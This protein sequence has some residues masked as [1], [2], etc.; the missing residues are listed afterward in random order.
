MSAITPPRYRMSILDADGNYYTGSLNTDS[1]WSISSSTTP[2]YL[3]SLPLNWQNMELT[4]AR[5]STYLGIVRSM[6]G[7]FEFATDGYAILKAFWYESG[8]QA[9]AQLQIE[10][11]MDTESYTGAGDFWRYEP[12]YV[13]N[14]DFSQAMVD[15]KVQRISVNTLDSALYELVK[16]Y[17]N[18]KYNIPFWDY[19][20]TSDSFTTEGTFLWHDGIKLLYNSMWESGATPSSIIQRQLGWTSGSNWDTIIPPTEPHTFLA[21]APV[22]YT[23]N[24]GT[25]TYIGND[26][27]QPWLLQ[28]SQSDEPNQTLWD[29]YS[30]NLYLLKCLAQSGTTLY[31]RVTANITNITYLNPAPGDMSM[32][33]KFRMYE[34]GFF[35]PGGGDTPTGVTDMDI[36]LPHQSGFSTGAVVSIAPGAVQW[37]SAAITLSYDKVYAL[38]ILYC[39]ATDPGG[40]DEA[41]VYLSSFSVAILSD[42]LSN[43]AHTTTTGSY[44]AYGAPMLQASPAIAY[45]PYQVFEKLVPCLNSIAT[46]AYG[47]PDIPPHTPYSGVSRFLTDARLHLAANADAIPALTLWTSGNALRDINGQPYISISLS[48]F[49]KVMRS[50]WGCGM[51]IE[52]DRLRI[53]PLTYFF[54]SSSMIIDLGSNVDKFCVRPLTEMLGNN[55][56]S[57]YNTESA[58]NDFGVDEWNREMDYKT[59]I[60]RVVQDIEAVC[61][62]ITS[63]YA[64]EKAR[65]QQSSQPI[66]SP[67][68]SNE[69]YLIGISEGT[70]SEVGVTPGTLTYPQGEGSYYTMAMLNKQPAMKNYDDGAGTPYV[71]NMYYGD[72][73]YNIELSPARNMARSSALWNSLFENSAGSPG[74]QFIHQYQ[75]LYNNIASELPGITSDLMNG[76]GEFTEVADIPV[77]SSPQLFRPYIL[78]IET[79]QPVNMYS[80]INHNAYGYIQFSWAGSQYQGFIWEVKQ[81]PEGRSTIFQLLCCPGVVLP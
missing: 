12:F 49:C 5:N 16:A 56:K 37:V 3:Q 65:A 67:S 15:M 7:T 78:E 30:K 10:M 13:S 1:S 68:S 47:F 69:N 57:G 80:I 20:S 34:I 41:S 25:T 23:Q 22:T 74:L 81:L 51:G 76:A 33:L 54:D 44:N 79:S 24:N 27:M 63:M 53:E 31:F 38:A 73:A 14:I 29:N 72:T 32:V 28:G 19:D 75:M 70:I 45:F 6:S 50:I 36:A 48:D 35:S 2:Q 59:P 66:E 55:L 58:N 11:R 21:L 71:T 8:I 43:P 9:Y 17:E 62:I 64:I 42:Y 77:N 26:I 40:T 4:W 61:P 39:S 52:G 18:T 60:T 46:N